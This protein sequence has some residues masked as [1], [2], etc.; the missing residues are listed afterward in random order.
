MAS[1]FSDMPPQILRQLFTLTRCA[2]ELPKSKNGI[3]EIRMKKVFVPFCVPKKG[4]RDRLSAF[5]NFRRTGNP[6][7]GGSPD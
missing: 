5:I 4:T 6:D 7:L 2:I 1:L 3:F